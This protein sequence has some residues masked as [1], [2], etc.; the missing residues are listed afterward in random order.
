MP[1][2]RWDGTSWVDVPKSAFATWDGSAWVEPAQGWHWDGAEWQ[3][4]WLTPPFIYP[5]TA[6]EFF[7]LDSVG[8][9]VW[10]PVVVSGKAVVDMNGYTYSET[11]DDEVRKFDADGATVWTTA[12]HGSFIVDVNVNKDG[13]SVV[14]A[15]NDNTVRKWDSTGAQVW[16][17]A[18]GQFNQGHAVA[19]GPD[20]HVYSG[21]GNSG[22]VNAFIIRK[23]DPSTG[24]EVWNTGVDSRVFA[25]AVAADNTVYV[26]L[27][28]GLVSKYRSTGGLVWTYAGLA[29][30]G[31]DIA[32]DDNGWVYACSAAATGR[33]H[34]ISQSM[35]LATWVYSDGDSDALQDLAVAEDGTI[36]VAAEKQDGTDGSVKR[37]SAAGDLIDTIPMGVETNG[38]AVDPGAGVV[39]GH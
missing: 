29:G 13:S 8:Y 21:A 30:D 28:S 18:L 1:M 32:V 10:G 34:K 5:A 17:F 3:P 7:K 2:N 11:F 23:H 26:V 6:G 39:A 35:G 36:F 4:I 38:I 37:V 24:A 31:R 12:A 16:S 19:V 9:E 20:G 15:S 14:S 27:N 25:I 33:L 22:G